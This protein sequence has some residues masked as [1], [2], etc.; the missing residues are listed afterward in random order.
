MGN[1]RL[2]LFITV[3]FSL[4]VILTLS[5]KGMALGRLKFNSPAFNKSSFNGVEFRL[6]KPDDYTS[7]DTRTYPLVVF[8]HGAGESGIDN[9]RQSLDL[10]YLGNGFSNQARSFRK[11]H[12]SFIYSPQAP[13]RTTWDGHNLDNVIATIEHLKSSY[14]IDIHRIY[15]IGYSMGG[16][17]TFSLAEKYHRQ[18][19]QLFAGIIRLAGQGNFPE[20][21]HSIISKSSLWLHIGLQ[22]TQ[23]RVNKAREAYAYQKKNQPQ[24]SESIEER[25][26]YNQ[27]VTTSTLKINDI[28]RFKLSEYSSQGHNINILPFED[29]SVIDW[30]FSKTIAP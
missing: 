14:P 26:A 1:L 20:H 7:N 2:H 30:L 18:N 13:K 28:E 9:R 15:L 29:P 8:L 21:V 23:L 6:S 25:K 4:L 12:P 16:S 5:G 24:A 11:K 3:L 10:S 22:D 27:T 19:G 17:G